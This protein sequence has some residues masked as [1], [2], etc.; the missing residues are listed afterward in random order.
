M[1][2]VDIISWVSGPK[3]SNGHMQKVC[4]RS[5]AMWTLSAYKRYYTSIQTPSIK[6]HL[7][8]SALWDY[9]RLT[10]F[11]SLYCQHKQQVST[12]AMGIYIH[13]YIYIFFYYFSVDNEQVFIYL[14]PLYRSFKKLLLP[15]IAL[16]QFKVFRPHWSFGF[17]YFALRRLMMCFSIHYM[18]SSDAVDMIEYRLLAI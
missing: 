8:F 16:W 9:M 13:I 11:F 10:N 1:C 18:R 3:C 4:C 12:F 6:L 5:C 7:T 2:K 14:G 17:E 15:P